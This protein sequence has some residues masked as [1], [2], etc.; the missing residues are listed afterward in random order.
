MP[1][2]PR[3]RKNHVKAKVP[4]KPKINSSEVSNT[5]DYTA[6]LSPCKQWHSVLKM[7]YDWPD[8]INKGG[9]TNRQKVMQMRGWREDDI[10]TPQDQ[11][12]L[13]RKVELAYTNGVKVQ[14]YPNPDL[15]W[16]KRG[17]DYHGY[18]WIAWTEAAKR[19][20]SKVPTPTLTD[21]SSLIDQ[22]I[23]HNAST[24]REWR[25]DPTKFAAF[26][27]KLLE[28]GERIAAKYNDTS[29]DHLRELR[30]SEASMICY[31]VADTLQ[32]MFFYR[33]AAQSLKRALDLGLKDSGRLALTQMVASKELR[34]E[35]MF[36]DKLWWW[37]RSRQKE[38]LQRAL[39]WFREPN[40]IRGKVSTANHHDEPEDTV[41]DV[42]MVYT[43]A[44]G[45]RIFNDRRESPRSLKVSPDYLHKKEYLDYTLVGLAGF[46]DSTAQYAIAMDEFPRFCLEYEQHL[47]KQNLKKQNPKE[48][49]SL[50]LDVHPYIQRLIGDIAIR[51]ELQGYVDRIVGTID[52][53]ESFQILM[54][55]R[56]TSSHD[57]IFHTMNQPML[58]AEMIFSNDFGRRVDFFGDGPIDVETAARLFVHWE[59]ECLRLTGESLD[60]LF[61]LEKLLRPAQSRWTPD[62]PEAERLPDSP[63]TKEAE[64]H[65]SASGRSGHTYVRDEVLPSVNDKPKTKGI[66]SWTDK[67]D[68]TK[69][70]TDQ[71]DAANSSDFNRIK[72]IFFVNSK[73]LELVR[74][75]FSEPGDEI[76]QGPVRWDD[77]YKLMNR[78]GFIIEAIGGS[79]IRFVPPNNAGLPFNE[80][81]PHPDVT[82]SSVRCRALGQKLHDRYGWTLEWF[83]RRS[84][85]E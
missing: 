58:K 23:D 68:V 77:I 35:F 24:F 80:H 11:A 75:L 84:E 22:A 10:T 69:S 45:P 72:P 52:S 63:V 17:D 2:P 62:H 37:K 78:L 6:L 1:G 81:R 9:L 48:G 50:R 47:K 32:N 76:S 82:I 26:V 38:D 44:S 13:D 74:K 33:G 71:A 27:N 5:V 59:D 65:P 41:H 40:W 8:R 36:L 79:V 46:F 12:D 43:Q 4:P 57:M 54:N 51:E 67:D 42:D 14:L 3:N 30:Q 19:A 34:K 55:D 85:K 18:S 16:P 66:S 28:G 21:V 73:Q 15:R 49:P 29:T 20:G 60:E 25:R 64:F 70:R 53:L 7:P 39:V 31:A 83:A 61:D 56:D